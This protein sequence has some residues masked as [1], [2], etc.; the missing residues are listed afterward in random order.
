MFRRNHLILVI[1]FLVFGIHVSFAEPF[2]P[3]NV[4][5]GMFDEQGRQPHTIIPMEIEEEEEEISTHFTSGSV[6]LLKSQFGGT[7]NCDD[8]DDDDDQYEMQLE[9]REGLCCS[10]E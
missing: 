7:S 10:C 1:L 4:L 9:E 2:T 5:R 6:S 3:G 8:D